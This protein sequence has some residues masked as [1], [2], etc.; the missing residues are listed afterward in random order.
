[1]GAVDA[2]QSPRRIYKLWPSSSVQSSRCQTNRSAWSPTHR[3]SSEPGSQNCGSLRTASSR[4]ESPRRRWRSRRP[5]GCPPES[6]SC[7]AL[8][9]NPAVS[10]M[11]L[12]LR[13][14][15]SRVG[16]C[17]VPGMASPHGAADRGAAVIATG[18][19]GEGH[20]RS[21]RLLAAER[22][23]VHGRHVDLNE[24]RL[25]FPLTMPPPICLDG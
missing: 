24:V 20:R 18:R 11:E 4:T 17:P 23:T 14:G 15:T 10:A 5:A 13:H 6:R 9:R 3:R 25:E 19:T 2:A 1:M 21:V 16:C 8:M 12:A 7:P 22:V